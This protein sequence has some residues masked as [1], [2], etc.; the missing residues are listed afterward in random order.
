M[1][2]YFYGTLQV[3]IG[4]TLCSFEHVSCII[5][6]CYTS[7]SVVSTAV[8]DGGLFVPTSVYKFI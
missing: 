5:F 3:G 2:Y 4:Q 6:N 7:F 1:I 8:C